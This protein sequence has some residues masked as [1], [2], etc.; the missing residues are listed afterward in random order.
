MNHKPFLFFIFFLALTVVPAAGK[1]LFEIGQQDA[2]AAE[3]ALYP[4]QYKSYLARFGGEKYYYVGY[5]TP[6]RHWSYVLPGPL[7]GFAGGGYWAGFHPRHFP[8][9]SFNVVEVSKAGDCNFTMNFVGINKSEATKIRIEVNGHRFEETLSENVE[10]ELLRGKSSTRSKEIRITF[11]ATWLTKGINNIRIG[12][13]QGSWAICDCLRLTAP[14]SVTL[15]SASSS[16]IHSVEAALFEYEQEDGTRVQPLLIRL[17]QFD[18]SRTLTV[19]IDGLP[20][21]SR[22]IEQG[23]SI[24]EIA[25]PAISSGKGTRKQ[26]VRILADGEVIY[27]GTI[28]RAPQPLH[29]YADYVDLLMGTGNSRWMFK[30][31]PCLPLSMVQIAPDNQNEGWKAGYEYTIENIAGFNHISDWTMTGFLMQPTCGKLQVNPGR[32]DCPD[33]GYRA[34]IDKK[35]EKAGIG[36]YSVYMTDTRIKAEITATKRA[37]L[38]RYTFPKADDARVLID[39]FAPN[40]YPY[41]LLEANVRQV[42]HTEIE[43]WATYRNTSTGYSLEQEYTLYFVLQ[44]SRPFDSMGGWINSVEKLIDGRPHA[45]ESPAEIRQGITSMEGKGDMGVFVNYRTKAND[46]VLVRSAISLVDMKGA[47]NNLR[48]ELTIPFDWDFTKVVDNARTIWNDYLG[49]ID[50]TTTD[51][52]QKKKFYTNLYRALASRAI[53]SDAD[54]RYCDE[55]ERIRQLGRPDDCIVSGEYWNTFWN[56]QPLFN[57]IAPEI[58]S[59]W[60]RSSILLYQNSGW[61]NTDPA[62]IEHTGVMVAMHCISQ[63]LGTWQSGIRDFNLIEAYEGLKKMMTTPPQKYLGGGTVGVEHLV[64]YMKYGYI[65]LGEGQVSNTMEYAYDDWCLGQMAKLLGKE[66]DYQFFDKRSD[67]WKALF[68]PVTGFVRPKDAKGNW[69]IPF[70]PYHTPG[71]TEGNAFNYSWFVPQKPEM[72]IDVVGRERFVERLDKAMEQSAHANFNAAGDNFSEFPINHGNE[73]SMEVAY[74]FNWAGAP[75][76]TQKWVRAIQEQYYGTTPYDAYPGDED[77]GQM[78]GWF[79]MSTLGLFQMEGGCSEQPFYEL[80]SPRYPKI[81]IRLDGKYGR[82]KTFTIEAPGA[83]AGNKYVRSVTLN[84]NSVEGFQIPQAELLKGGTMVI[85]MDSVPK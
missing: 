58:S 19:D 53:W 9:I 15:G 34:R 29:T 48:E 33:E 18:T 45:F 10:T 40:E 83:S 36:S 31:G 77:L 73:T 75:W 68:D 47:R 67:S 20:C 82:G 57:L 44:F 43:G 84:G 32:E 12:T 16:L 72:L 78:S 85:Q 49:R 60:A 17:M 74:L 56:L 24:Q 35:S 30:P 52:L 62:G 23:E 38:Q 41:T 39:L 51:F 59:K 8:T 27:R 76:L 6:T 81:T 7:D 22:L 65:P 5:S 61:F 55:N 1:T 46:E 26:E 71:F 3:F 28:V 70:D 11:P 13:I 63:I 69:V 21:V 54:G 2:S 64:P 4:N 80:G 25:M 66:S 79:V 42:S 50:I 14:E 37:A